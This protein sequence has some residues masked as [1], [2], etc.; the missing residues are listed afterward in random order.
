MAAVPLS[1]PAREAARL[2]G[3]S[4]AIG[5]RERRWTQREL[6]DR[7]GVSE[8]TVRKVERGDP[9]VALGTTLEAAVLV[10]APLFDADADR[11]AL[12][13]ARATDRLA[14]LPATVHRPQPVDDDF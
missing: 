10:G 5:R 13:V 9:S 11:R 3:L 12:A 6:A 4:V 2:L 1:A 14:L 7:L 8:V